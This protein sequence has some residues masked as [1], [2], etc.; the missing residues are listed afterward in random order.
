M[1]PDISLQLYER[2]SACR[3]AAHIVVQGPG[4]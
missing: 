4:S 2:M 3:E 1:G